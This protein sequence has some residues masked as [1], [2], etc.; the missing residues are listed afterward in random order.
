MRL[1]RDGITVVIPA[2]WEGRVFRLPGTGPTMHAANFPLP[3]VDGNFGAAATSSMSDDGVFVA[4]VEYE[5]ALAGRGLFSSSGVPAP[6]AARHMSPRA[7]Q[8]LAPG[9]S[10]VQRFFTEAGRAFCL[11]AVIGSRPSRDALV[12]RVNDVV[13]SMHIDPRSTARG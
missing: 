8:R 5:P 12:G 1:S 11:Y 4:L 10:G 13:S 9:R 3:P 7:M 2:G 6:L